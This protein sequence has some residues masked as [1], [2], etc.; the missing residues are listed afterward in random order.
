MRSFCTRKAGFGCMMRRHAGLPLHERRGVHTDA[1]CVGSPTAGMWHCMLGYSS[2]VSATS[3]ITRRKT[4][5]LSQKVIRTRL[6]PPTNATALRDASGP[7]RMIDVYYGPGGFGDKVR[8]EQEFRVRRTR[9][10]HRG[11]DGGM[12]KHSSPPHKSGVQTQH[13]LTCLTVRLYL[14]K[15]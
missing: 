2:G 1:P 3:R 10:N 4:R 7:G 14:F 15:G 13:E 6:S 11:Q 9:E 12:A 8:Q 5:R